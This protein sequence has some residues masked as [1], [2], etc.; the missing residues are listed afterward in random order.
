MESAAK[1]LQNKESPLAAEVLELCGILQQKEQKLQQKEQLLD[2]IQLLRQ[3]R[4]G[5]RAEHVSKD[6]I[7]PFDEAELEALLAEFN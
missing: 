4:F 6:Q 7:N 2:S 1:L 3:K 5:R